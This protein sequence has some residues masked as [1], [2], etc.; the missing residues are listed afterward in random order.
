[1]CQEGH[2]ELV[3]VAMAIELEAC[4]CENLASVSHLAASK[5]RTLLSAG[6]LVSALF[7]KVGGLTDRL[8]SFL[9]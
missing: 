7:W 3:A 6:V 2:T 4:M 1:M 8:Q 9:L 5:T